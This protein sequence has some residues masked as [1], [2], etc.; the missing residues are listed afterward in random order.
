MSSSPASLNI[1]PASDIT[2]GSELNASS[3]YP[4]SSFLFE[5]HRRAMCIVSAANPRSRTPWFSITCRSN[6]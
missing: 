4:P 2:F 3:E 6:E 1:S 5:F